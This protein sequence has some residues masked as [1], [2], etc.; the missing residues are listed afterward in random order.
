MDT[1]YNNE[2]SHTARGDDELPHSLPQRRQRPTANHFGFS[3][4]PPDDYYDHPQPQY[5]MPRTS[6]REEDS[7]I[8]TIFDNMHPLTIDG[9]MTSKRLLRFFICLEIEFGYDASKHVK[10]SALPRLTHDMPNNMIQDMTRYEDAKNFLMF[11]LARDCNQM[12]LKYE[13]AS[14]TPEVR[15]EPPTF[16]TKA[17]SVL[18][19]RKAEIRTVERPIL[20]NQVDSEVKPPMSPWPFDRCF[21]RCG[22]MDHSQNRYRDCSFSTDYCPQNLV[23]LPTKFVSFQPQPLEQ[24]PLPPLCTELL[25]EQLIQRYDRDEEERKSRQRME[26]N[27][28]SNRQQS[29]HHQS[30]S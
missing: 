6:H 1:L 20:V 22:S 28:P 4:Y 16:L 13:F 18:D 29:P 2:F 14:I 21:D 27:L 8:K 10:M 5:K 23:P 9:A 11:Q 3:D 26:E 12:T 24:P 25:L 30:Q 19:A 17:Q 7:R 15:E